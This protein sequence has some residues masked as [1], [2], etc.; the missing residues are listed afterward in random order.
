MYT[1]GKIEI[2]KGVE[3]LKKGYEKYKVVE[4]KA[5]STNVYELILTP[6]DGSQIQ[7]EPGQFF[8]LKVGL[9]M[10]PLL[11]RPLSINDL[12]DNKISFLH[13]VVGRGTEILSKLK[14]DDTVEIMGPIG[15]GFDLNV[16]GKIALVSGGAG[17]APMRYLC[18]KLK[19]EID[20]YAGFRDEV[21]GIE[22]L[23]DCAK[24]IYIATESG[25]EGHKGFVT[26][27]LIP[28]NYDYVISCGPTPMMKVV[29]KMCEGKTNLYLSL[30]SR[31]A[32]GVGACTGCS[33]ENITGRKH[34]CK[35]GPVFKGEEVILQ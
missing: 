24:N 15:N 12:K 20:I 28:E 22:D 13:E 2:G 16:E 7:G 8:M 31:M 1:N 21:F 10:D 11:P 33:C 18:K 23:K 25:R 29:Q 32:C 17:I 26:D 34:V 3:T 6:E 35:D 19:G 5:L 27:N 9:E 14:L 4:N 30:E